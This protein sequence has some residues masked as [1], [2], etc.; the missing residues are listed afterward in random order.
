MHCKVCDH[1]QI[2]EIEAAKNASQ[3][4]RYIS[5]KFNLPI[6]SVH[7]HFKHVKREKE[8][9][10]ETVTSI[11]AT[12]AQPL[13]TRK[14]LPHNIVEDAIDWVQDAKLRAVVLANKTEPRV[15]AIGIQ[16]IL[17]A[18]E[19][20]CRV[21]GLYQQQQSPILTQKAQESSTQSATQYDQLL[22]E[23]ILAATPEQLAQF[24]V[25]KQ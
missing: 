16:L 10:H 7:Y 9:I 5:N 3:S 19:V 1:P 22:K 21:V 17:K 6:S 8:E 4:Y 2:A 15:Q 12:L 14:S 18:A 23:M 13:E 20:S 24:G 11:A 25:V